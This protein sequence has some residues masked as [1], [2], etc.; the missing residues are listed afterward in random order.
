M[1]CHSIVAEVLPR[2]D[3]L[4]AVGDPRELLLRALCGQRGQ[5]IA[6]QKSTPRKYSWTFG[7]TFRWTL[8][9]IFHRI[10]TFQQYFPKDCHFP[11][12]LL[13]APRDC[14]H[15]IPRLHS[16][17]RLPEVSGDFRRLL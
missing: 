10:F 16:P 5:K 12:R 11:K 15:R 8:S 9:G 3:H 1:L 13:R 4:W 7:G 14:I 6:R 2:H 17:G